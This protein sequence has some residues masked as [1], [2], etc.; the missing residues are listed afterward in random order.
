MLRGSGARAGRVGVAD[1]PS[2]ATGAFLK[3]Q[4]E[5]DM[6]KGFASPFRTRILE[7][8]VVQKRASSHDKGASIARSR[9]P[10]RLKAPLADT[11]NINDEFVV[12]NYFLDMLHITTEYAFLTFHA[13]PI[14][15][16]HDQTGRETA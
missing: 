1:P 7:C 9:S 12:H 8:A 15:Q 13:S 4:L 10:A 3:I 11:I 14:Q 5:T 2:L 16:V 6:K